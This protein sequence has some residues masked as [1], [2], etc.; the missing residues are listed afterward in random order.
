[1]KEGEKKLDAAKAIDRPKTIWISRRKPPDDGIP[2][3][4][5]IASIGCLG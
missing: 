3:I 5:S 2:M 4:G 1:L